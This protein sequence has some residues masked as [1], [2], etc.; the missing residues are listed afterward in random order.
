ML[1]SCTN[2]S[3]HK[4]LSTKTPR[5]TSEDRRPKELSFPMCYPCV[6]RVVGL[7]SSINKEHLHLPKLVVCFL[8]PNLSLVKVQHNRRS[9]EE[10]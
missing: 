10:G 3:G 8:L 4:D 7:L 6:Y 9:Y 5:R 1:D 2:K